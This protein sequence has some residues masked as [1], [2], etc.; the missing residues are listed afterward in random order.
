MG[1]L[2]PHPAVTSHEVG[3]VIDVIGRTQEEA[4]AVCSVARSAMLHYGYEGR[5]AT[6]GNL[7]FPFSPSDIK[8]GPVY[9][10]SVYHLLEAADEN[11]L[12][13]PEMY[14]IGPEQIG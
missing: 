14:R 8:A 11:E 2:E 5:I 3:I 13:R 6:A 12:F 10:F 9:G 1:N 4:N 7:A